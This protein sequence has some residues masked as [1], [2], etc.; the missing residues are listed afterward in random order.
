MAD[1]ISNLTTVGTQVAVLFILIG[2]GASLRLL[3]ILDDAAAKGMTSLLLSAVTICLLIISFQRECTPPQ[4]QIVGVAAGL[5]VLFHAISIALAYLLIHDKDKSRKAVLR[6]SLIFSNA[7]YMSLPLQEAILGLDGVF[8]GAVVVGVFQLIVWTYG[9]WQISGDIKT[10]SFKKLATN[11]GLIGL[12]IAMIL[13]FSKTTLP[14]VISQPCRHM[15][16]LN[17]PLAMLIIGY[18]L[19]GAKI[20]GIVKDIKALFAIA[21]RLLISPLLFLLCIY[22]FGIT[23]KNLVIATMIAASAP[24]AAITTIF[25]VQYRPTQIDLSVELVSLSTL[26]SIISMP[27]I[28]ALALMICS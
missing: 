15:S 17:T 21:L 16:N 6:F 26:I 8:V 25:A 12:A 11:P 3:K 18:H 22:L 27:I 4:L 23:D 28:V 5:A 9:L 10:F 2:I 13:F 19:A 7:G 14:E 20:S 24:S 1:F